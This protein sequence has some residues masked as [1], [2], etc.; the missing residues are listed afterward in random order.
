MIDKKFLYDYLNAYSPTA[1]EGEGQSIWINQIGSY[2]DETKVDAYGTAYGIKHS[3]SSD[4]PKVIIEAHCDEIAWIITNIEESGMIRVKR[5]GGSDNMIAPS[6]TVIIHT[7][8]GDKV[9]GVFGWP[10]IHTRKEQTSKGYEQDELWIDTG[11]EDKEVVELAGVEIGNIVTYDTQLEQIGDYYVGRSLDNKIGGVIIAEVAKRLSEENIVLPY[12]LYI[13]NSVQEEV[14]LHGAKLIAKQLNA[15]L[16]IVTDVCHNTNTPGMNKAKDGDVKGGKGPVFEYTAQNHRKVIKQ[17]RYVADQRG[18]PYQ[19][20]VGSYGN[21]TVAFFLENTPTAIISMPLK[22]MHTTV[23]MAHVE[24]VEHCINL[25]VDYL[26][27][28]TINDI[29]D[30]NNKP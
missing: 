21:D 6:R 12:N 24:D 27:N 10:A 16:A 23:E 18:I 7:H 5:H 11:L 8:D 22:Y 19:L 17:L 14:G 15:D 13:V 4:A 28:L 9:R 2:V 1:Q 26:K 29:K 25:Y 20:A 3:Y 30:I